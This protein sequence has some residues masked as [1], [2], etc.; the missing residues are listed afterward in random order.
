MKVMQIGLGLIGTAIT[1]LLLR[2][3]GWNI[4]AAVDTDPAK[5]GRDLGEIAGLRQRLGI[6][7]QGQLPDLHPHDIDVAF[8]TTV[9]TFPEVLPTLES[10]V[11][12]GIDV[13]ASTEELFFPY[14]RYAAQATALDDLAKKHGASILGAGINP[15]F[16][17]DTLVLVLTS[18]C[19]Q[20]TRI[21][22][23]R[24]VNASGRRL[25]LQ[26]KIGV[27]L[28]PEAFAAEV[29]QHRVGVVGLVDSVAFLAHVLTWHMDDVRER[30]VPVIADKPFLQAQCRVEPGQVCGI[31]HVVKGIAQGKEAISLDLRMYLDAENAR[32]TI[33]IEGTPPLESTMKSSDME[34]V[35]AAGLLV[36]MSPLVQQAR[37]GLLT[38][39]DLPLPHF[40][41]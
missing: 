22:V 37:A 20:I 28:T 6:S 16:V 10:L 24:V 11:R 3:P 36:N 15:G 27:G 4:V 17:M 25:S 32:D 26:R 29:A 14:Y 40:Q 13:V 38:M 31:R 18:V 39:V 34:D 21:A 23:T 19:Q 30:F 9:S 2:K 12:A 8:L 33:Y 5:Q 41:R 7:V 35:A 1:R